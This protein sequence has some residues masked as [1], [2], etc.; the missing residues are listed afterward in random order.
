MSITRTKLL[1]LLFLILAVVCAPAQKINLGTQ[2][3]GH[4]PAANGGVPAGGLIGQ[5]MVKNSNADYDANWITING[6]S[7]TLPPASTSALGGVYAKDCS[8][9][10]PSYAVQK[11]NTDGTETCVLITGLPS[12]AANQIVATPDGSG[13]VSGLRFMTPDDVPSLPATKIPQASGSQPGY[14]SAGDYTTF[15]Q[16][17]GYAPAGIPQSTGSAWGTSLTFDTDPWLAGFSNTSIPSQAAVRAYVSEASAAHSP[18]EYAITGTAGVDQSSLWQTMVN[19]LGLLPGGA[20]LQLLPD[21]EYMLHDVSVPNNV[22]IKGCNKASGFIWEQSVL[23]ACNIDVEQGIGFLYVDNA[24]HS[25]YGEGYA[26]LQDISFINRG[27]ANCVTFVT[28]INAALGIDHMSALNTNVSRQGDASCDVAIQ[29]G[30]TGS[31]PGRTSSNYFT[32]YDSYA[33]DIYCAEGCT[34]IREYSN[35]NTIPV[36][37]FYSSQFSGHTTGGLLEVSGNSGFA[38]YGGFF[39]NVSCELNHAKYCIN[40]AAHANSFYANGVNCSDGGAGTTACINHGATSMH[41]FGVINI[42]QVGTV[43]AITDAS[44]GGTNRY[45]DMA[46]PSNTLIGKW[47]GV[48]QGAGS[49]DKVLSTD[50]YVDR[51]VGWESTRAQS[52]EAAKE[53]AL[54]NPSTNGFCVTSTTGGTR[55]WAACGSSQSWPVGSAGVPIFNGISGWNGVYNDANP[56]PF[57]YLTGVAAA[58]HTHA[59]A[60]VTGLVAD[61]AAKQPSITANGIVK[62]DGAGNCSAAVANTDYDKHAASV[63]TTWTMIQS[64]NGVSVLVGT[65][66]T[67]LPSNLTAG[68]YE[69]EVNEAQLNNSTDCDVFPTVAFDLY[70]KELDS[71]VVLSPGN[72]PWTFAVNN[73]SSSY[74]NMTLAAV[75]T[76]VQIGVGRHQ[77]RFATGT[78]VTYQMLQNNQAT[79]AGAACAIYPQI[80]TTV[81][82]T[83][84]MS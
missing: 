8:Q 60:D 57:N 43:A 73:A 45:I 1:V 19:D 64:S 65:P 48:T 3:Q 41:N 17:A 27:T 33:N 34:G 6:D 82:V 9:L 38:T 58:T 5:A 47:Y 39:T 14:L 20:T 84:P 46:N 70:F 28:D 52:A 24:T 54:G 44:A 13:G 50:E 36:N 7:Y 29:Y 78:A 81:S 23:P 72:G 2:V 75:P 37:N 21:D 61:L 74:N 26:G 83:G 71:G 62:C 76:R 10:G 25:D 80:K 32:G 69:V 56:I 4:L 42:Y 59:E 15:M 31:T 51:T 40:Y 12:G 16:K 79:K 66:I 77:F 67:A 53:P 63:T 22:K 11:I 30:G 68:K 49:D 55:S 18:R 35:A